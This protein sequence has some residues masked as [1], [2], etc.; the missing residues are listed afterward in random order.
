MFRSP[1]LVLLSLSVL[2]AACEKKKTETTGKSVAEYNEMVRKY[3]ELKDKSYDSSEAAIETNKEIRAM[4]DLLQQFAAS[5]EAFLVNGSPNEQGLN[6]VR[7]E[8]LA[9]KVMIS[10]VELQLLAEASQLQ[11]N[12]ANLY[13]FPERRI[14]ALS[15]QSYSLE[16]IRAEHDLIMKAVEAHAS[17]K[18]V[19]VPAPAKQIQLAPIEKKVVETRNGSGIYRD[20]S[21]TSSSVSPE[22]FLDFAGSLG[23]DRRTAEDSSKIAGKHAGVVG[24]AC[25]NQDLIAVLNDLVSHMKGKMNSNADDLELAFAIDYSGSM[26]NNIKQVLDNVVVFAENLKNIKA[27]GRGVKVAIVTFGLSGREKVELPMTSDLVAFSAKLQDLL[28]NY[29]RNQHST[30]PGEAIYAGLN[31]LLSEIPFTSQN[32]QIIAITDEPAYE[33]QVNDL[34]LISRV[35]RKLAGFNIYPLV[36]RYCD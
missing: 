18:S 8:H 35:D 2:I 31:K 1:L 13:K 6:K 20:R 12:A 3:N 11:K 17:A 28:A 7:S 5:A 34:D 26:N 33:I 25:G 23:Y 27:S 21:G 16:G 19:I 10:S 30:D 32:R 15:R 14:S 9:G 4:S 24:L 29:G 22:K 36:V